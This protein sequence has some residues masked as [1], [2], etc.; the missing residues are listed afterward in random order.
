MAGNNN[1][2]ETKDML[3]NKRLA[4]TWAKS[5]QIVRNFYE[6]YLNF[7]NNAQKLLAV[8]FFYFLGDVSSYS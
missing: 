5:A 6:K 3:L 4:L 7:R 8:G 2:K 1:R